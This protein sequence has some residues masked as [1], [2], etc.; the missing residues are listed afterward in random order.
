MENKEILEN[1][2]KI[3]TKERIKQ[4]MSAYEL[5]I[6]L[7]KDPSYIN[8]VENGKINI[9]LKMILEICEILKIEPKTLF[10]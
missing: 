7:G 2:E 1:L 9:S 8:K 3:I 5:S 10:N 4:N 6:K